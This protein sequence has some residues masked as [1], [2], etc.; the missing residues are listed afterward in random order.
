M[1]RGTSGEGAAM[2]GGVFCGIMASLSG[3]LTIVTT[4][5]A[6]ERAGCRC[7][8]TRPQ[9]APVRPPSGR[10]RGAGRPLR[11]AGHEAGRAPGRHR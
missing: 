6:G 11:P 7:P 2:G 9:N 4:A 5:E 10:R 8:A 3:A 1:M